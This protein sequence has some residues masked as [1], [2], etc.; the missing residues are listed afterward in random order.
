[1]DDYLKVEKMRYEKLNV[2]V[3]MNDFKVKLIFNQSYKISDVCG[4]FDFNVHR[5]YNCPL[6]CRNIDK[7]GKEYTILVYPCDKC[8]IL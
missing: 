1:M 3:R 6:L 5:I 2:V 8:K 4:S 7:K